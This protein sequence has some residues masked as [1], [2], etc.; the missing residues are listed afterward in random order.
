MSRRVD[1][2]Y[3][4]AILLGFVTGCSQNIPPDEALERVRR[5]GGE[6]AALNVDSTSDEWQKAAEHYYPPAYRDYFEAMD[7]VGTTKDRGTTQLKLEPG[8]IVGR[9]A[10]V[11]WTGGN[12]AW[13]DW[14]ARHGY[15]T[16]DLLKL[17]DDRSRETRFNRTGLI[18]EPGTRP[19]MEEETA[20]AFGVRYARP[21]TD[22]STGR[23]I[24]VEY[25]KDRENW[26]PPNPTVYGY[27]TGVI[28]LRL[29]PN[30]EFN[31][32]AKRRWDPK[33]Y[34]SETE[35]GR[36]YSRNPSTIRP[37]RVG[38]SCGYCHIA[39]HPLKPPHDPEFPEWE[40]LSNNIG[41]QFMRMRVAFANT[42]E[43][44]NYLYQVFDSM[45]PGAVDTSGHPS[46]NNN[47]PNTVNS[48]FGLRGRLERARVTPAEFLSH[49]S[50]AYVRGYTDEGKDNPKHLPKVLLDGSD[51]VGVHLA[52]SRVYLNIGT[53]HQQWL[54][55]INPFIGFRKQ[56]PFKLKDVSANSL[57]WHAIRIRIQPMASFFTVATDPMRLKDVQI[58]RAD[59]Q[60]DQAATDELLK[61]HLRGT[62]LP[63]YTT[64]PKDAPAAVGDEPIISDQGNYAA[65]RRA[66][67]RGCIACHSSIQPGDLPEL[68]QKLSI[69]VSAD[70]TT[71][72]GKETQ[73]AH[74]QDKE[75]QVEAHSRVLPPIGQLPAE[76]W[77][78]KR[79]DWD[80]MLSE[81]LASRRRLRLT[82]DDRARLTHG[83]G[84][85]PQ[86]YAEWARQAVEQRE[87]WE[88]QSRLWERDGSPVLDSDGRHQKRVTV[89]NYLSIDE[90]IPI[91]VVGT[92]SARATA[93]NS[94][95]GHVWEDFASQTFKE[96][97]AV[98]KIRFRDPFSGATK[99][100]SPPGGGIGYYRVP[101]L[102]SVWA[103]APF[104]HNNALGT[105][106]N[107]PT[108]AGRLA[109]FDDA[110]HRL[111]WP[112]KRR[113]PSNQ[114]YWP[115]QGVATNLPDAWYE[116]K[117]A[118]RE[119]TEPHAWPSADA[120][121]KA[122]SQR[123]LDEG[124]IWRTTKES[125]L[126]IDAPHVPMLVGGV[127][128]INREQMQLIAFLPPLAFLGLGIGLLLSGRINSIWDRFKDRL[129]WLAWLLGPFRWIFSFGGLLLAAAS[130]YF[131][132][133]QFRPTVE[134]LDLGTGGEIPFFKLQAFL[135]PVLLFGSAGLLL[136]PPRIASGSIAA[137]PQGFG[138]RWFALLV[139]VVGVACLVISVLTAMG[140][141]RTLAGMGA[142]L[143]IG[144]I[145][146]GIPVSIIANVDPL[147]PPKDLF[148]AADKLVAF[149]S[150]HQVAAYKNPTDEVARAAR[151]KEFEDVCAPA[152]LKVSKCPDFI[153]DRGHDFTF[154]RDMTDEEKLELIQ[155]IKTF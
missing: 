93:T 27:P 9:N 10:W 69:A 91:T 21:I 60:L 79:S 148:D 5:E 136:F 137:P 53:H 121:D 140:I 65:G 45:L 98:G 68:E 3:L 89:H 111:L 23:E 57:Y 105:F 141:G 151:R 20:N 47:N 115:G 7:S 4:W 100:Y 99:S 38:M 73:A 124:W 54:N 117:N 155:L 80:K 112:D 67:A 75:N 41:N 130:G 85:L 145:P 66:F 152:L 70:K 90:R 103:T 19:P 77:V 50:L 13:W 131:V 49:D 1:H 127:A 154:I 76:D 37:Y 153:L 62:G 132:L 118:S 81:S 15:G 128:G 94:L 35:E 46:D 139:R 78:G 18:N 97:D 32:A 129:T 64:P 150:K 123:T 42:I 134:L 40:N 146:E 48:F 72:D 34:Y 16:I 86:A 133:S 63:W 149:L 109:A 122:A 44:D 51:S 119:L 83:D 106:N 12:E 52:L 26:A 55:T 30:P 138:S 108:V 71:G 96:L 11:I 61:K 14:L 33:L 25:R 120:S 58:S 74:D 104:F 114:H 107:D 43:P 59:G 6:Y 22:P 88:H 82:G 101:T 125:W 17:I 135:I 92:N 31:G 126:K 24:H 36:K 142:G 143:R 2:V 87:F 28:G 8:Q 147:A 113:L 110:I 39:P 116:G 95:H 29:F 144:P 56:S 102:I 84:E